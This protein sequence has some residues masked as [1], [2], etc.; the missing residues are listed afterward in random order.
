MAK[1]AVR[2]SAGCSEAPRRLRAGRRGLGGEGGASA[3][4]RNP[5]ME[6][7]ET[8]RSSPQPGPWI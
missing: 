6:K 4:R 3:A 7:K 8:F 5:R 2:A 1:L